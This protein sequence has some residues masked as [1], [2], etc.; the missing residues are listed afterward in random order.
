[1]K[2]PPSITINYNSFQGL[3]F[4]GH[5]SMKKFHMLQLCLQAKG[6]KPCLFS[7]HLNIFSLEEG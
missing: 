4:S 7:R 1:M 3:A 5:N 6:H 2:Q